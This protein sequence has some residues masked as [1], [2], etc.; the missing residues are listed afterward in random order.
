MEEILKPMSCAEGSS[1]LRLLDQTCLTGWV[2]E[3][4]G[5]PKEKEG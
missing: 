3:Q 1:T 5:S 2:S 4:L